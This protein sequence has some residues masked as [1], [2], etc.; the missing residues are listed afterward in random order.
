LTIAASVVATAPVA[1]TERPMRFVCADR[2]WFEVTRNQN[3]ATVRLGKRE[4]NLRFKRGSI[5]QRYVGSSATLIID[6]DFAAF[7]ADDATGL[8]SCRL[9]T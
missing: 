4:Y 7:V 8:R 3:V 9:R 1:A 2:Q 6:G 5:G